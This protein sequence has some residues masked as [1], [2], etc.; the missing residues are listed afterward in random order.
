MLEAEDEV[1][2]VCLARLD[3]AQGI[4]QRI[5]YEVRYEVPAD[6]AGV[7]LTTPAVW[8]L[9]MA[10]AGAACMDFVKV[11]TFTLQ[12]PGLLLTAQRDIACL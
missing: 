8:T 7:F 11:G 1:R 2:P 9:V 12:S 10:F 4:G 5:E 6:P 3:A